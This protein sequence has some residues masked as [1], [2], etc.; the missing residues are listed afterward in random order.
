MIAAGYGQ[1]MAQNV[2]YSGGVQYSA[3]AYYFEETTKSFYLTNGFSWQTDRYSLSASFPFVVQSTPW[4]S[5][6]EFGG[7]PTGG[8]QSGEVHQSGRRNHGG[9]NGEGRNRLALSDTTSY[10][11]A[12]FSDPSLSASLNLYSNAARRISVSLNG[13]VKIPLTNPSTGYGTGAWD[14]GAG[15]AVSNSFRT[16]WMVFVSAMYWWMGDM[17]ELEL[18]NT[19]AYGVSVGRMTQGGRLLVTTSFN[20]FT[21]I[22]DEFDPPLTIGLGAGLR[23]SRVVF[24]NSHL[25][26][27]LSEAAPDLSAGAGWSIRF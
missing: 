27:G 11:R 8:T 22:A 19:L 9:G 4:V 13:Q 2:V 25:T 10:T 21:R 12:G 26:F 18:N 5:Y 7:V 16:Q 23:A 1:S 6:T 15:L 20:G 24:L 17:D 14:T 3:G